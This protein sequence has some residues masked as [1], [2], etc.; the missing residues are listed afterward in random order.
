ML[1]YPHAFNYYLNSLT[2]TEYQL[3]LICVKERSPQVLLTEAVLW[4][5]CSY[6][7]V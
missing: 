4:F 2:F 3:L 6:L 7:S 1:H 5:L